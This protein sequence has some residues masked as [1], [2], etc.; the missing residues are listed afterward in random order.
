MITRSALLGFTLL[1][2]VS[3]VIA[4]GCNS[5]P[6]APSNGAEQD[7]IPVAKENLF[8]QAEVCSLILKRHE[9]VR[10]VD[11]KDGSIRWNCA[12]VPGVTSIDIAKCQAKRKAV[13]DLNAKGASQ[14]EITNAT[15]DA[16]RECQ[17]FGQEYCEYTAVA[18]GKPITKLSEASGAPIQCVFTS[19]FKD[20]QGSEALQQAM[21]AKENLGVAATAN[22]IVHMQVGFNSRGA[23]TALFEDCHEAGQRASHEKELVNE[24]RQAACWQASVADPSKKDALAAA[25][26]D[27]DLSDDTAWKPAEDLGAKV[28]D[29]SAP[30]YDQQKDLAACLGVKRGNGVTWR[31]SDNMICLRVLRGADECSCNWNELPDALTGFSLVGW[32]NDKLPQGCRYAKVD[33]KDHD[34][35]AI[36]DVTAS[37]ADDLVGGPQENDLQAFCHD[38]FSKDIVMR[39]PA[40]AVMVP[41]SCTGTGKYC[42][43]FQGK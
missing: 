30:G 24:A 2:A 16:R 26:R 31:N 35:I 40:R 14:E 22:S 9:V 13:Q 1:S 34:N 41:N 29:P 8:D 4:V 18:N 32:T 6:A 39:A 28:L 25:C 17:G 10:S 7:I 23:A 21:A 33:G 27:K 42:S 5:G 38:R 3:T 15:M 12:D 37:E 43:D 20:T 19:L 36:C 11:M